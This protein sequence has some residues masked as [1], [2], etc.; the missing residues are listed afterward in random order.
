MLCL[1]WLHSK[2]KS[3]R[4]KQYLEWLICEICSRGREIK[5][6]NAAMTIILKQ[7]IQ[8]I[9]CE[10]TNSPC[11]CD[12]YRYNHYVMSDCAKCRCYIELVHIFENPWFAFSSTTCGSDMSTLD[13]FVFCSLLSGVMLTLRWLSAWS[14]ED[15]A[16]SADLL[17]GRF[18]LFPKQCVRRSSRVEISRSKTW[19]KK[20]AVYSTDQE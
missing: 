14:A 5:M 4:T 12:D 16:S 11:P 18:C 13:I 3:S 19:K 6:I 9:K 15:F 10:K 8:S 2:S 1:R 7:M 20:H 17:L